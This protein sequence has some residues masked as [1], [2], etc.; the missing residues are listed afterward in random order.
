MLLIKISQ[1]YRE[2]VFVYI[3]LM[4]WLFHVYLNLI[5]DLYENCRKQNI[6]NTFTAALL[7]K[8]FA[9]SD[10]IAGTVITHFISFNSILMNWFLTSSNKDCFK[11][12]NDSENTT[13]ADIALPLS[14]LIKSC[15]SSDLKKKEHINWMLQ[16][17]VWYEY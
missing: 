14:S 17:S 7:M 8:A 15:W 13:R 3:N 4:I 5:W 10:Q 12:R 11:Y 1:K 9:G 6:K 16:N 2:G